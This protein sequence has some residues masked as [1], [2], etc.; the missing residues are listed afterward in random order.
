[1]SMPSP[2][3]PF[4][5]LLARYAA[6]FKAAWAARDQLAGPQRLA[7]ELA[8]LPAA[9]ALQ[10]T[11]PHPAPRRAAITICALFVITLAWAYLGELDIVAVAQGRIQV[12]DGSK[13]IQPLE[14]SVVKA[15]YVKDGDKVR[16]GQVLIELDSTLPEAEA[17]RAQDEQTAVQAELLRAQA[18]MAALMTGNLPLAPPL[19]AS[20][21]APATVSAAD[22]QALLAEWQDISAKLAKLRAEAQRREAERNTV[23][24]Q[25]AKLQATL[26]LVAQRERDYRALTTQGFISQHAEQDRA[27]ERVSQERDLATALARRAEAQAAIKEGAESAKA[28]RSETLRNLQD[29]ATQAELK[30]KQL[31]EAVVKAQTRRKQ[32]QLSAPVAGT[33]QQLA[34]HT[35]GGVVTAAQVLAVVV[36]DDAAVTAEV[37]L[38]NKD[39]GYIQIGQA[40]E[41]KLETFPHTH[42]GVVAGRVSQISADS[43]NDEKRG[44]LFPATLVLAQT[45]L[46]VDGRTI[47]LSPGM[48]LTAEIKTGKRRVID[49]L[50]RP[51]QTHA[52]ESLKER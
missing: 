25:I 42:Y 49:Y 30:F 19:S 13:L 1:M 28:Y 17:R 48:N 4:A 2:Q 37:T 31:S 5:E 22:T 41:I 24:Q 43:V 26:P 21:S 6:I 46:D 15:I 29:R 8:F 18:L 11:P 39:V 23:E 44:A 20:L 38:E 12:S 45:T 27:L 33:V 52:N 7:D 35:S 36:P 32:T 47:R 14:T 9:M 16:A 34:I 40:A 50:L 10:E 51:L 3:H